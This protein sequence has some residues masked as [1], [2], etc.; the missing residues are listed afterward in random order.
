MD[1]RTSDEAFARQLGESPLANAALV[2]YAA[3]GE[4][5][6][7]LRKLCDRYKDRKDAG[8]SPPTVRLE[9]LEEWSKKYQWQRRV[10]VYDQEERAKRLKAQ[11]GDI[12][13]MNKRHIQ[14]A[15]ALLGKALLWLKEADN[16]VTKPADVIQFAKLAI[17]IERRARGLPTELLNLS[18]MSNEQLLQMH[19]DLLNALRAEVAGDEGLGDD[20][21]A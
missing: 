19:A 6:R 3:M 13:T 7:S 4:G 20:G 14:T 2:D 1:W 21:G 8:A 15:Q 12:E 16:T 5:E 18:T 17:D 10:A 11:Q 9:T